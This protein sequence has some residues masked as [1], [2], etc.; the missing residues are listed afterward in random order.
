M[1][2]N[3]FK[4]VIELPELNKSGIAGKMFPNNKNARTA[5]NNKING[6][7]YGNDT[8]RHLTDED[9]KKGEDVL[10]NLANDILEAVNS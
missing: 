7:Q 5:L 4:R 8:V 9:L 3:E 1:N 2:E 6:K 10:R